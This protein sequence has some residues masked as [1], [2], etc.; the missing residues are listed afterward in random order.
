MH[1]QCD[2]QETTKHHRFPRVC[3]QADRSDDEAR[4]VCGPQAQAM[5]AW[6]LG[7][8]RRHA[9][10]RPTTPCPAT[11]R[12]E[13]PFNHTSTNIELGRREQAPHPSLFLWCAP[14]AG[15]RYQRW[16]SAHATPRHA[17]LLP[18]TPQLC[19]GVCT[20]HHGAHR[21][22]RLVQA[23]SSP[24]QPGAPPPALIRCGRHN[25]SRTA[26]C[27]SD[28]PRH[29]HSHTGLCTFQM[30]DSMRR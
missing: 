3:K 21:G 1:A 18:A 28:A 5:P 7:P 6:A 24:E 16:Q 14:A 25:Q 13:Q 29:T 19:T 4:F 22:S 15:P 23:R 17:P 2:R 9:T 27:V 20:A 11:P 26:R 8:P 12:P 10:P 30:K